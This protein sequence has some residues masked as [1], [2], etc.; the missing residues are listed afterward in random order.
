MVRGMSGR[1]ADSISPQSSV[2][3]VV[4]V[5]DQPVVAEVDG[6]RLR[7]QLRQLRGSMTLVE[8]ARRGRLNRDELSRLER[9]DTTQVRFS[10][11]AKLVAMYGCSLDDLIAIERQPEGTPLYG[12]ALAAL[13]DGTVPASGPGRRAVLRSVHGDLVPNGDENEFA[14]SDHVRG[15]RRRAA[16]GTVHP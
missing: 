11:L 10:T 16:V 14:P 13:A 7:L 4:E 12:G 1:L 9:G 15:G 3:F 6:V 5:K 2:D 8:V